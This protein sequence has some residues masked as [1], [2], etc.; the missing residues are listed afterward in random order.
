MAHYT[1]RVTLRSQTASTQRTQCRDYPLLSSACHVAVLYV[2]G[3]GRQRYQQG[4]NDMGVSYTS[5]DSTR[6][7]TIAWQQ[8]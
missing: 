5:Y 3:G 7:A 1:Y 2:S 4:K 6:H 8:A